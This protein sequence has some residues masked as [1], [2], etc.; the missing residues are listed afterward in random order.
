MMPPYSPFSF[1]GSHVPQPSL[2]VGGWNLPSYGSNP[3]FSFLGASAQMGGHSTYY[4]LSIYPSSTMSVPMKDFPM[5]DLHLSSGISSGGSQFYSMG[6]PLHEV[7]SSGGNIYPHMSNPCLVVD[8]SQA[9]SLVSMPLHPFMNQYGGYY[10]SGQG[11]GVY[12]NPS[13]PAISQNQSFSK[14]WSQMAQ[15]TATT[16]SVTAIHTGIISPTFASHV[17]DW[18]TT[19]AI[20]VED[21]QTADAIH[22][23]GTSPVTASHTGIISPTSASH[24]GDWSTTSASHVEDQQPVLQVMLGAQVQSLQVILHYITNLC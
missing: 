11:H 18:S 2:T 3:S 20:H 19:S 22:A 6:N 23:G 9:V 13:W 10:P 7:P 4:I 5:T 14:P 21:Q 17:G 8:S 24:V 15:P 1:V 12:Q 16:S